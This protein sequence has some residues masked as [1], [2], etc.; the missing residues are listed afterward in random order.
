MQTI[1]H[2][3]RKEAVSSP[4]AQRTLYALELSPDTFV[5]LCAALHARGYR[6]DSAAYVGTGRSPRFY[7]AVEEERPSAA[8]PIP[9]TAILEEFGVRIAAASMLCCLGEH[10]HCLAEHDAVAKIAALHVPRAAREK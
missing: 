6:A 5:R 8:H 1:A 2:P 4:P 7:L 3:P 9:P 10:A